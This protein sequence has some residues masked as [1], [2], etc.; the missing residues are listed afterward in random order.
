MPDDGDA[1]DLASIPDDKPV[2]SAVQGEVAA[3]QNQDGSAVPSAVSGM[4][5]EM[6]DTDAVTGAA[7]IMPAEVVSLDL[8]E[9]DEA[10]GE[11]MSGGGSELTRYEPMENEDGLMVLALAERRRLDELARI[12]T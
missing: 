6:A 7:E 4:E 8:D 5:M 12:Q 10:E 11:D 2:T 1:H 9:M 3:I